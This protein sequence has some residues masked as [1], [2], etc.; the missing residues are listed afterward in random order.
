MQDKKRWR[1]FSPAQ[2]AAIVVGAAIEIVLTTTALVDL[3]KRPRTQ[4]RGPKLLWLVALVV[5]P[6]GPISYLAFGRR[7]PAGSSASL[8]SQSQPV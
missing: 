4:V 1:D 5:Q 2:R 6:V 3:A 8:V 7:P